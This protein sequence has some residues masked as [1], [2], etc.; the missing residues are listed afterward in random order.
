LPAGP[1]GYGDAGPGTCLA[2]PVDLQFFSSGGQDFLAVSNA[3]PFITYRDGS[4]LVLEAA[5]L[6]GPAWRTLDQLP[7]WSLELPRY[8]GEIGLVG[9]RPDG[10]LL[11]LVPSRESDGGLTTTYP[12]AVHLVDLSDPRNPV[13]WSKPLE[14]GPDPFAVEVAGDRAFVLNATENTLSSVGVHLDPPTVQSFNSEAEISRSR[15][16]DRDASGSTATLAEPTVLAP[17]NLPT[18]VWTLTYSD[19]SWRVWS[20]DSDGIL[21]RS[22][23]S[24]ASVVPATGSDL[25]EADF[26]AEPHSPFAFVVA[27]DEED[28][29]PRPALLVSAG[30]NLWRATASSSS[31]LSAW[32]AEDGPLLRARAGGW[33]AILG[34]AS[35]FTRDSGLGMVVE[36][37]AFDGGPGSLGLATS[38]DG[39]LWSKADNPILI[40]TEGA[41]FADPFGLRDPFGDDVRIWLSVRSAEGL[42]S[43]A[44]SRSPDEVEWSPVTTVNGLPSDVASPAVVIAGGRYQLWYVRW[45]DDGWM[46]ARADSWDGTNWVDTRDVS[47]LDA[48]DPLDPPRPAPAVDSDGGFLVDNRG[49][50]PLTS[51]AYE[52]VAVETDGLRFRAITGFLLDGARVQPEFAAGGLLPGA[53]ATVG[54]GTRLWAT[55]YGDDNVARIAS[56]H[57]EGTSLVWESLSLEED[58]SASDPVVLAVDGGWRMWFAAPDG[59]GDLAVFTAFSADG[60]AFVPSPDPVLDLR[61]EGWARDGLRP[62]SVEVIE[63]GY[64]LWYTGIDGEKPRIGSAT[65]TDGLVFTPERGPDGSGWQ[66]AAGAPGSFDDSGV[67]DPRFFQWEGVDYLVYTGSD[68]ENSSVGLLVRTSAGW[69]RGAQQSGPGKA[70]LS[71]VA[72]TFLAGG[73][74]SAVPLVQ[75]GQVH[76]IFAGWDREGGLPR[77]GEASGDRVALNPRIRW[78]TPGDTLTFSTVTGSGSESAF[79]LGQRVGGLRAGR[80]ADLH[81]DAERGLLWVPTREGG[82]IAAL[83]VRKDSDLGFVDPIDVHEA[84]LRVR[85]VNGGFRSVLS[86]PGEDILYALS[87]APDA[88]VVL[89]LASLVDDA[90]PD[91]LDVPV[92]ATLP[93]RRQSFAAGETNDEGSR[94]GGA[95][96]ALAEIGG[97][98]LLF[99][100][101]FLSND[102]E[103]FDLDRGR[104]GEQIG[105]VANVGEN[106]HAL[107]VRPDGRRVVVANYL[108]EEDDRYVSATLVVIDSDPA[109]PTFLQ[110][111]SRLGNQ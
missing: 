40:P 99:V 33:D 24:D 23:G 93:L 32:Q 55:V 37:R 84:M 42:W 53:R 86:V 85:A 88:L 47:L 100:T 1:Y 43:I 15:F 4:L 107:A 13:A 9:D 98:R 73:V 27:G 35:L 76:V 14:V 60:T 52:G 2:G 111:L 54:D 38:S 3:D 39:D 50:P 16:V 59:E 96:M 68:G 21:R 17:G 56:F 110:V 41:S 61:E 29:A 75:K 67:S 45:T 90:A 26:G 65:S 79:D 57:E 108:G 91:V 92:L 20:E 25:S 109:S 7:A 46:L 63:G 77:I 31:G 83:D 71:P 8:T 70:W 11:A 72:G 5:S 104:Y 18:D 10:R 82:L 106:P 19:P 94:I 30:G 49:S 87:T 74:G 58:I 28:A 44:E 69:Q 34:G 103:V 101:H 105:V 66:V 97:R 102:V 6:D 95:R 12:D 81:Y 48:A 64:R 62:G 22:V 51:L 78:A 80:A 36:G 89:D